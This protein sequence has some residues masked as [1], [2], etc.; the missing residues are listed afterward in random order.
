L[1]AQSG[2]HSRR[3]CASVRIFKLQFFY[4]RINCV[5]CQK[6]LGCCETMIPR[7]TYFGR[8]VGELQPMD[9]AEHYIR[10]PGCGGWIDRRD[11]GQVLAHAGELPH[12]SMPVG[13]PQ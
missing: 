13:H 7:G 6:C 8:P 4:S 12:A 2:Y 5:E 9:E 1:Q 10:C 11:L 3:A